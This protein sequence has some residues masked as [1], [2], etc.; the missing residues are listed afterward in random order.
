MKFN[1]RIISAILVSIFA[2]VLVGTRTG[3]GPYDSGSEDITVLVT[4]EGLTGSIS[5][6]SVST[7][8]NGNA[9]LA[10]IPDLTQRLDRF[11]IFLP[12]NTSG[13]LGV[14]L[15]G[16][17]ADNCVVAKGQA[18]VDIKPAP[19]T[20]VRLSVP[21]SSSAVGASK[22]CALKVELYGRGKITSTPEGIDCSAT[23]GAAV[24]CSGDFPVGTMITLNS[25]TDNKVYGVSFD[26]LCK[27]AGSCNFQFSGPGT[28]R[29]GFG[30]RVCTK[31]N[32]CWYNPLPHGNPIRGVWGSAVDDYWAVGDVGTILHFDGGAWSGAAPAGFTQSDLYAVYGT[33][34]TDVWAVGSNSGLVRYNGTS[35]TASPQSGAIPTPTQVLRG[36]WGR[37]PNDYWAVGSGGVILHFDG[38]SWSEATGS[39]SLTTQTLFAVWGGSGSDVWAVGSNATVLRYN[40]TSWSVDAA[41]SAVSPGTTWYSVAG[42]GTDRV[43]AVGSSGRVM[44]F[45]G[46]SWS[47]DPMSGS[48]GL[49][50]AYSAWMTSGGALAIGNAS[51]GGFGSSR[52]DGNTW[53]FTAAPGGLTLYGIWGS[54]LTDAW[55]VGEL[56]TLLHYDGQTWTAPSISAPRSNFTFQNVWGSAP[57]DVWAVGSSGTIRRFNG[58]S[59]SSVASGTTNGLQNVWGF[60]ST[61][62]FAVGTSGTFLKYDGTAW[63]PITYSGV[64][65]TNTLNGVWGSSATSVWAV[66]SGGIFV[67]YNGTMATPNPAG[68]T[69]TNATLYAAHGVNA[70]GIFAVG[71]S[72]LCPPGGAVNCNIHRYFTSWTPSTF[73]GAASTATLLGIWGY[74][75]PNTRYWAVGTSGA[76]AYFDG[77]TWT[78]NAQSGVLTTGTLYDIWGTAPNNIF[79]V[80]NSPNILRYDGSTW[81]LMEP[82]TRSYAL[83]GVWTGATNDAWAVGSSGAL[84]RYMP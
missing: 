33:S 28:V 49:S 10:P 19:P 14:S 13:R 6:L 53:Q 34:K 48:I 58:E 60:N 55:A 67:S 38:S 80:G 18:E 68:G 62:V 54:S 45:N 47:L 81:S 56:G 40:G 3:C 59:W 50:T 31:D 73:A 74:S 71:S 77:S 42:S 20:F 35:W 78:T 51:S 26:G 9:S 69:L 76:I 36:L 84:L 64:A 1:A 22:Q 52:F 32:W 23:G 2:L 8:L 83:Y 82:G 5:S 4:V 30:E 46:T 70:N 72:S 75:T 27:S 12:R 65:P 16:H 61:N 44:R 29:V 37:A 15:V 63:S 24:T 41:A 66:G 43:I 79:A 21:I 11:A 7:T 17:S 57:T 39:R 25:T